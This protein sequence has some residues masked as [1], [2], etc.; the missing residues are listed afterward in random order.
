MC[1]SIYTHIYIEY[2]YIYKH[3]QAYLRTSLK[4]HGDLYTTA[5]SFIS[6][7][8]IHIKSKSLRRFQK[9]C[10]FPTL[11]ASFVYI[12]DACLGSGG[13]S[14]ACLAAQFSKVEEVHGATVAV[15]DMPFW[16]CTIVVHHPKRSSPHLGS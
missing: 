15:K 6:V 16:G 2:I 9:G 10:A 8:G 12:L 3:V 4:Y 7:G 5:K 13:A 14:L 1:T 11:T